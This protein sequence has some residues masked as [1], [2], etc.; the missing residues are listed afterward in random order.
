MNLLNSILILC[1]WRLWNMNTPILV[2]F[3]PWKACNNGLLTWEYLALKKVADSNMC[4]I[5]GL[6]KDNVLVLWT[7]AA[8][9]D[10]WCVAN[11]ELQNLTN[12]FLD[13]MNLIVSLMTILD[14]MEFAKLA[15]DHSC[16]LLFSLQLLWLNYKTTIMRELAIPIKS[17][18]QF[19]Y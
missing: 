11:W 18:F 3:I 16:I 14:Q 10:V 2:K 7:C 5:C 1:W 17:I 8:T 12:C 6:A 13:F 4:P 15:N 19:Q 9:G